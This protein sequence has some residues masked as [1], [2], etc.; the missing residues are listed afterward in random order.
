MVNV[1]RIILYKWGITS[2]LLIT[3]MFNTKTTGKTILEGAAVSEER[4]HVMERASGPER[5]CIEET[6]LETS[7]GSR[8]SSNW[9]AYA[10]D[11]EMEVVKPIPMDYTRKDDM[12]REIVM[13]FLP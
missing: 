12:V 7:A 6:T 4:D 1:N 13:S 10:S 3:R 8:I 2:T 9:V 5:S 11:L